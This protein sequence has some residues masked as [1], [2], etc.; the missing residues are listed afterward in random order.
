MMISFVKGVSFME[1]SN[2]IFEFLRN[3][4]KNPKIFITGV[5][6][7]GKTYLAKK[8][9]EKLNIEYYDFDVHF[10]KDKEDKI[11]IISVNTD[12]KYEEK[13]LNN[14]PNSF[15]TDAIPYTSRYHYFRKYRKNN[16]DVLVI[17]TLKSDIIKWMKNVINKNFYTVKD[18]Y[19]R[20]NP[21]YKIN[22]YDA[23]LY[24]Y[25]TE[26]LEIRP[27]FFYDSILNKM[28]IIEEFRKIKEDIIAQLEKLK[29]KNQPLLKD[30]LDTFDPTIHDKFYQDIE[31]IKF[32]GYSKSYETWN[33][34][35]DLVDWKGKSIID[36]GCYHGYFCFKAEHAGASRV[37]GLEK[38]D[39]IL[40]ITRMIKHINKSFVDF[41]IW[42][43]GQ[44]TPQA[45]IA[46]ILNLLHHIPNVDETLQNIKAKIGIF[47]IE[48]SQ[49][50]LVKKYYKIIREVQ[51]H[52][53]DA[54]QDRIILLGEKI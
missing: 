28:V 23:W 10:G 27:T 53:K 20:D 25:N 16:Q 15:V 49:I 24:F 40:E 26:I 4:L 32:I 12:P 17:C 50:E 6:A 47:E 3:N 19:D 52:R 22:Y 36:L 35:K 37:I 5:T 54:K 1:D 39:V 48:K 8:I 46:L 38:F 18:C 34:I 51:S 41:Q 30:Y 11:G 9:S 21:L 33:R 43:C 31:C 42:E 44:E 14:L 29:R 13:F 2:E 45:D 7:T